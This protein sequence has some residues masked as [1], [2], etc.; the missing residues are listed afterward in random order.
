M[1]LLNKLMELDPWTKDWIKEKLFHEI[2]NQFFIRAQLAA[3]TGGSYGCGFITFYE[4]RLRNKSMVSS[5]S[6]K[7]KYK[8]FRDV[9]AQSGW[10]GT[11]DLVQKFE[12]QLTYVSYKCTVDAVGFWNVIRLGD[13]FRSLGSFD[14]LQN[15]TILAEDLRNLTQSGETE[16]AHGSDVVFPSMCMPSII[17]MRRVLPGTF[18]AESTGLPVLPY[19][20]VNLLRTHC[21]QAFPRRNHTLVSY[22]KHALPAAETLACEPTGTHVCLEQLSRATATTTQRHILNG[23]QKKG[24]KRLQRAGSVLRKQ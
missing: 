23:E 16:A 13:R 19:L 4:D 1:K 5:G 3:D 18:I 11:D 6:Q 24:K 14:P 2:P 8:A 20:C 9:A 21:T 7:V 22:N 10:P 15:N 17:S 12:Q